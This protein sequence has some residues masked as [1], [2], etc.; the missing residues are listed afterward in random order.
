MQH[1][2]SKY[3]YRLFTIVQ[4]GQAKVAMTTGC[5]CCLKRG[6]TVRNRGDSFDSEPF[7]G[8]LPV[9]ISRGQRDLTIKFA[10]LLGDNQSDQNIVD[11]VQRG[12]E[13]TGEPVD[14]GARLD[15]IRAD[16]A[17]CAGNQRRVGEADKCLSA[18]CVDFLALE[19]TDRLD[20]RA[21]DQ[22]DD[23]HLD[24]TEEDIADEL[25]RNHDVRDDGACDHT[26]NHRKEDLEGAVFE[27]FVHTI[28]LS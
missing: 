9:L 20:D 24:E 21:H 18:Q 12:A 14:A 26:Q 4:S 2:I 1:E 16:D 8:E 3:I 11:D 13:H 23:G 5:N 17:D 6:K 28:I 7:Y 25:G 27:K 19:R 15:Q 10:L 22:Y